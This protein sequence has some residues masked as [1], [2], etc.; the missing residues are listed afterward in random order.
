MTPSKVR[1]RPIQNPGAQPPPPP[2]AV[3][4]PAGESFEIQS[5]SPLIALLQDNGRTPTHPLTAKGAAKAKEVTAVDVQKAETAYRQAE[6]F[7][8][9]GKISETFKALEKAYLL[10]PNS[11]KI[12]GTLSQLLVAGGQPMLAYALLSDYLERFPDSVPLRLGRS[13][14]GQMLLPFMKQAAA[15]A[16]PK[17][18]K[19]MLEQTEHVALLSLTDQAIA[20]HSNAG[21]ARATLQEFKSIS[22]DLHKKSLEEKSAILLNLNSQADSFLNLSKLPTLSGTEGEAI[23]KELKALGD[24]VTNLVIEFAEQDSDPQLKDQVLLLKGN[25]ALA[26]GD[27]D[28]ASANFE[29]YRKK[30]CEKLGGGDADKGLTELKSKFALAK[31]LDKEG[32]VEE[33]A[34]TV[35][36]I[37]APLLIAHDFLENLNKQKLRTANLMA[38]DAMREN[39]ASSAKAARDEVGGVGHFFDVMWSGDP[40]EF[41]EI[42]SKEFKKQNVISAVYTRIVNGKFDTVNEALKDIYENGAAD[43]KDAALELLASSGTELP[44]GPVGPGRFA[45]YGSS[46]KP[47]TAEGKEILAQADEWAKSD[48]V[49]LKEAAAGLYVMVHTLSQDAGQR[50]EAKKS[51]DALP[52]AIRKTK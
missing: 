23:S 4:V 49:N 36:G 5:N 34:K 9:K 27:L 29:A 7:N 1:Q 30:E 26:A 32:N 6:V 11:E 3:H 44:F 48:D 39:I 41:D 8:K 52:E 37:P 13:Q 10:N 15:K 24:E 31:R 45:H 50:A 28:T 47:D 19:E 17:D 25:K 46:T 51:F 2:P 12:V 21:K 33:A 40:T 22:G 42:Q 14:V 38:L 43:E 20:I 16:D 18:Q 35:E